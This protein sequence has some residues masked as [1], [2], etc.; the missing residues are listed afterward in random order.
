M[1]GIILDL[2]IV[3]IIAL[4]VY[5]CYKKGLVNL[6]V[7]LIAV[8][9]AIILSVMFYKPI[10][11][12][13]IENTGLDETIENTLNETFGEQ[14]R[15]LGLANYLETEAENIVNG[16]E[17]EAGYVGAS[18][19][20]D[21]TVSLIVFI[22]IFTIV[23]VALFALT[24]VADA[25]TSLPILKQLDDV[26]GIAYGLIKALL[27]IYLVLAIVTVVVSFIEGTTITDAISSSYITKF[28]YENNVILNILL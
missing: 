6:A 3:A 9:A 4:N 26:G 27:I 25:I 12:L 11:N 20:A 13:V 24:F 21:T 1:V 7:G 23:R 17:N 19:M 8:V 15:F 2:V 16:T 18:V 22:A 5:L 14:V 10:T 28:F